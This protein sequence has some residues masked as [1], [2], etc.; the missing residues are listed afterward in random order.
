M[1][2]RGLE[3]EA[4]IKRMKA[5][6]K[7]IENAL[8]A[9]ALRAPHMPLNDEGREGRQALLAGPGGIV[10]PVVFESDIIPATIPE[11]GNQHQGIAR[12]A[13]DPDVFARLWSPS[14][15]LERVAKD[16][17]EYRRALREYLA[18]GPAALVLLASITRDKNGIPRSRTVIGWE[19]AGEARDSR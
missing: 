6:L 8:E 12:A 13:G 19:R 9:E 5:E 17:K 1:I 4:E 15:K 14:M 7:Q 2:G 18:P 10:L 16:G 3:I 11:G